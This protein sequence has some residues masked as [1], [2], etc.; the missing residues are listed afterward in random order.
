[1][2]RYHGAMQIPAGLSAVAANLTPA[3]AACTSR[4]PAHPGGS[5]SSAATNAAQ[6]PGAQGQ[7]AQGNGAAGAGS[8][9][10]ATGLQG[11]FVKVVH[12]VLPSVV[13]IK[14]S[15]GLGSGVIFDKAGHI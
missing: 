1:M 13:E 3:A 9:Q 14:T 8:L 5:R 12:G 15:E 6:Q 10:S 11:A 4:G 7:G 2:A